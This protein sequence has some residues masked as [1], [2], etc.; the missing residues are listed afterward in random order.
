[1]PSA[2]VTVTI[3]CD[4]K[5]NGETTEQED[6][7]H[8]VSKNYAS[9]AGAMG[10]KVFE[11][12]LSVIASQTD[13]SCL[14]Q[15]YRK[16]KVNSLSISENSTGETYVTINAGCKVIG[17]SRGSYTVVSAYNG[18]E[19]TGV[20]NLKMP[21]IDKKGILKLKKIKNV[22]IY[23]V[24]LKGP[25]GLIRIRVIDVKFDP[26]IKKATINSNPVTTSGTVSGNSVSGNS[27]SGNS[28]EGI[29][30]DVTD[31]VFKSTGLLNGV[32]KV[33][34]DS[35]V[36]QVGVRQL[37]S[38][39]SKVSVYAT[40]MNDGTLLVE[41]VT[42]VKAKVNVKYNLNGKVYKTKLDLSNVG[43]PA[44][45]VAY[46]EMFVKGFEVNKNQIVVVNR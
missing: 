46:R 25:K 34:K 19:W 8:E 31:S 20:S 12:P 41:P 37:I 6:F 35:Y 9:M 39:N 38:V 16:G 7:Y 32:W 17:L 44:S 4:R 45:K 24:C 1:M 33:G 23:T 21:K 26:Q 36:T 5:D 29:I 30:L 40:V 18:T 13:D 43:V 11:G 22:P 15:N 14:I 42:P 28:T 2:D 3:I 10:S 27:V